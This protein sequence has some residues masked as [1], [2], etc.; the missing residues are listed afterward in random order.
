MP[1]A[2]KRKL[3]LATTKNG[4]ATQVLEGE[5]MKGRVLSTDNFECDYPLV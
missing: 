3:K 1:C 4:I 5:G 2:N